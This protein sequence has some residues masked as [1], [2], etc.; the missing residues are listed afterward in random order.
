MTDPQPTPQ[1]ANTPPAPYAGDDTV[2]IPPFMPRPAAVGKPVIPVSAPAATP[3]APDVR[4]APVA[5]VMT[6][7]THRLSLAVQ[8]QDVNGVLLWEADGTMGHTRL[9]VRPPQEVM[10]RTAVIQLYLSDGEG[11]TPADTYVASLKCGC[12]VQYH[13]RPGLVGHCPRHAA[14]AVLGVKYPGT[15]G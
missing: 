2:R 5:A 12:I 15:T 9:H 10:A 13:Y 1:K 11:G 8:L 3:A 14:Q 6:L 7:T 4:L